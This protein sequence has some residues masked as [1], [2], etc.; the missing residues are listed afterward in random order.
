MRKKWNQ[1]SSLTRSEKCLLLTAWVVLQVTAVWL[2]TA[3]LRRTQQF[4]LRYARPGV[5]GANKCLVADVVAQ[6]YAL[7]LGWLVNAASRY[8]VVPSSCLARA[9]VTWLLLQRLG[10]AVGIRIGVNK[11]LDSFRAHA[12]VEYNGHVANDLPNTPTQ[13]QPFSVVFGLTK[14]GE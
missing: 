3:G 4:L 12:W 6:Q 10:I 9:L 11:G 1:F 14:G 7:R 8:T 5:Q 2:R 13:Y